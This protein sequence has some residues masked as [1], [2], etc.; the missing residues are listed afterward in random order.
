MDMEIYSIL[1]NAF[2]FNPAHPN[3]MY[4]ITREQTFK[5]WPSQLVQK[6]ANL[7]Q[8]GFFYT[9]IG[10]RVTCFYCGVSLKQW[11]KEDMVETEHLKYEP[12]CLFAKMVSNK[13]PRFDVLN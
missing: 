1:L 5:N 8:N 7:T 6:P 3:M 10:D 4:Y 11:N 13:V 9:D 2:R 12:N